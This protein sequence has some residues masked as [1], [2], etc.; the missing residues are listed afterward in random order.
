MSSHLKS[1]FLYFRVINLLKFIKID[2]VPFFSSESFYSVYNDLISNLTL[3]SQ[4]ILFAIN[5]R[6]KDFILLKGI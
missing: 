1:F 6:Q 2:N 5:C 3:N 4:E